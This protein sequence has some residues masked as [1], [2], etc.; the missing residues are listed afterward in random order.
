MHTAW[1]EAVPTKVKYTQKYYFIRFERI[2]I[3][4]AHTLHAPIHTNCSSQRI[5]K[6][7]LHS[8]SQRESVYTIGLA[9]THNIRYTERTHKTLART[10]SVQT[11]EIEYVCVPGRVCVSYVYEWRTIWLDFSCETRRPSLCYFS[12]CRSHRSATANECMLFVH[13]NKKILF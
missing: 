3:T 9:T 11:N 6:I 13:R 12:W 10:F 4:A 7:R 1:C 2:H 8:T 5:H